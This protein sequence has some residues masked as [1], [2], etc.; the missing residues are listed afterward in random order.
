VCVCVCVC[1]LQVYRPSLGQKVC[2]VW[3]PHRWD[4]QTDRRDTR[5]MLYAFHCVLLPL[6]L[7]YTR[8]CIYVNVSEA[9]TGD[10]GVMIHNCSMVAAD[11]SRRQH[12]LIVNGYE[13]QPFTTI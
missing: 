9:S 13:L 6:V 7:Y 4:R 10:K 8:L 1:V 5:L 3:W 12:P 11:S 2:N